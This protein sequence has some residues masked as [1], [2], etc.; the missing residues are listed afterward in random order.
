MHTRRQALVRGAVAGAGVLAGGLYSPRGARAG[1]TSADQRRADDFAALVD[2]LT[3]TPQVSADDSTDAKGRLAKH[4]DAL[5]DEQRAF[6]ENTLDSLTTPSGKRLSS[7]AKEERLKGLR[8]QVVLRHSE[9]FP[10]PFKR[11]QEIALVVAAL[12]LVA[13]ALTGLPPALAPKIAI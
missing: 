13:E 1:A 5:A 7:V 4:L 3:T 11:Q 8:A 2:A 6:A 12:E 9:T 10:L